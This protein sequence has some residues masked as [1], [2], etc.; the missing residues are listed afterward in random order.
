MKKPKKPLPGRQALKRAAAKATKRAAAPTKPKARSKPKPLELPRRTRTKKA[1]A[2]EPRMSRKATGKPA[3]EPEPVDEGSGQSPAPA[4]PTAREAPA[5][6][7][8]DESA[9]ETAARD[10]AVRAQVQDFVENLP[11]GAEE[12]L[13]SATAQDR[14]SNGPYQPDIPDGTYDVRDEDWLITFRAGRLYAATHRSRAVQTDPPHEIRIGYPEPR[15]G[16]A[17]P[18]PSGKSNEAREMD[19]KE[20]RYQ[21]QKV[22]VVRPARQGDKGFNP[23]GG[24][25]V[26]IKLSDGSERTVAKSDVSENAT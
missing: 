18:A 11:P 3:S 25:Q 8:P 15:D 20:T 12:G 14:W 23:S 10:R 16:A 5:G 24:E 21:G 9:E 26:V 1:K 6:G 19:K 22:E 13:Y 2:K 17:P 7:P 4:K